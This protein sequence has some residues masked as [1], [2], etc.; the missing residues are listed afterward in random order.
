MTR[1]LWVLAVVVL[2]ALGGSASAQTQPATPP[3]TVGAPV[4]AG[5]VPALDLDQFFASLSPEG[6]STMPTPRLTSCTLVQCRA[7]CK[8]PGCFSDC[9]DLE[10][11]TCEAICG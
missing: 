3:A 11:C 6:I 9:I 10:S 4:A 1:A 2:F 8:I 7:R 5:Q